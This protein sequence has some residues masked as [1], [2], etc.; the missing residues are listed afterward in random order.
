MVIFLYKIGLLFAS[1]LLGSIPNGLWIGKVFLKIDLR[2]EGSKN[3][4]ASNAIRVMGFYL[5]SLTLLLDALKAAIVVLLVRFVLPL[6]Y[7][8][9]L[10]GNTTFNITVLYGVLAVFG[11]TFPIYINFKGGKAVAP[12]LGV[13]ASLT[14][15][16][17]LAALV[18]Y[19]LVAV[20][21]KY[22]SVG[23]TFATFVVGIG[24]IIQ[25]AIQG[26]LQS[27]L[28]LIVIYWLMILFIFYRHIPNFK[29]LL[30][31]EENKMTLGQKKTKN[32]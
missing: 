31:G 16:I 18:T 11:H 3:I 15:I 27:D 2:E 6:E 7:S 23:T 21:T 22:A 13:V 4:G 26:R 29:R 8:T 12:S 19:I 32:E 28:F 30:K 9:L 25:F 17:G 5:G 14:P 1:Y 20:I 24:V 10:I